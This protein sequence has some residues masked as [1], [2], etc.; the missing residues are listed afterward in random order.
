MQAVRERCVKS[1]LTL[2]SALQE[3]V[4][5]AKVWQKVWQKI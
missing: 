2:E 5:Q 3:K 1:P 4:L